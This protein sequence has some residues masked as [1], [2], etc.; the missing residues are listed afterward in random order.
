[1]RS[2]EDYI[3]VVEDDDDIREVLVEIL[4]ERGYASCT[5]SNGEEALAFLRAAGPPCLILLDQMMPI[6]GG[7]ELIGVLRGTPALADT[8]ICVLTADV[9]FAPG[10]VD[11]VI[12]KP[13]DEGALL[14]VVDHHCRRRVTWTS[15][16]RL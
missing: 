9:R 12:T 1:M 10:D 2:S 15:A 8:P 7:E 4:Y 3:L 16:A 13:I 5:A 14:K 6:M 11:A